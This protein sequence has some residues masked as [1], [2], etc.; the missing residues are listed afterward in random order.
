MSFFGTC[1]LLEALLPLTRIFGLWDKGCLV[2]GKESR[3]TSATETVL[4]LKL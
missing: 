2:K 3:Q 4:S 1:F